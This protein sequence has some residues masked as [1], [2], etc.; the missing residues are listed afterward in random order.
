MRWGDRGPWLHMTIPTAKAP[1]FDSRN[2]EALR[3]GERQ[4]AAS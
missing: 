1:R 4:S 3:E 2:Q